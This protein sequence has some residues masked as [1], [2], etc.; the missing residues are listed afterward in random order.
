MPDKV[1]ETNN[2]NSTPWNPRAYCLNER[3]DK[4]DIRETILGMD[5]F[6]APVPSFNFEGREKIGSWPGI[7]CS[8]IYLFILASF[9]W[10]KITKFNTTSQTPVFNE[11]VLVNGWTTED[12][13]DLTNERM[14]GAFAF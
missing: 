14:R 6:G 2:K 8:L 3:Y 5:L 9:T 7:L 4:V 1:E 11:A 10:F 12:K 13:L